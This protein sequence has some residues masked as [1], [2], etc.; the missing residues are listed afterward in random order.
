MGLPQ[1]LQREDEVAAAAL[2]LKLVRG[3][4][5]AQVHGHAVPEVDGLRSPARPLSADRTH[6]LLGRHLAGLVEGGKPGGGHDV[7]S[8]AGGML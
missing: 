7:V 1:S 5:L 4:P 2:R 3:M 6:D 8:V